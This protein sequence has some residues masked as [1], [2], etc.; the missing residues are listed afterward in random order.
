MLLQLR[1]VTVYMVTYFSAHPLHALPDGVY[2]IFV[3]VE[4]IVIQC[5]F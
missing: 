2:K 1:G 3:W 5:N 4:F